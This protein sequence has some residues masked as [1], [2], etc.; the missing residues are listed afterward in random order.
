VVWLV[1]VRWGVVGVGLAAVLAGW[2]L[3]PAAACWEGLLA[4]VAGVGASNVVWAGRIR[5]GANAGCGENVRFSLWQVVADFVFLAVAVHLAGGIAGPL[6]PLFVLHGVFSAVLLPSAYALGVAGWAALLLVSSVLLERVWG[7]LPMF[8]LGDPGFGPAWFSPLLSFGFLGLAAGGASLIGLQL[9]GQLRTRHA[10]VAELA[11]ELSLRNAA[12][13]EVDEQRLRLLGVAS[14]DL[15]GPLAAMESR[16]DLFLGGYLGDLTTDQRTHLERVQARLREL[17]DF[18][19]DLLDLTAV[20]TTTAPVPEAET[21]DVARQ[22]RDAVSEMTPWAESKGV[23]LELVGAD[24][25]RSVRAPRAR[26]GLVWS[27]LLS[28]GVKY[29]GG[30]PVAVSVE[31][32]DRYVRVVVRDRGPG[33]PAEQLGRLFTEFY[34]TPAA[35]ASGIPGTGLGLAISRRVVRTAGGGIDVRSEP[36]EGTSFTVRLPLVEPEEPPG[37]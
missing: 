8:R 35:K 9:A 11:G 23:P 7:W 17:R 36:G 13:R 16:L 19:K 10:R 29:G 21:F 24:R 14:H 28:N 31:D 22:V 3:W 32:D 4:V 27:N 18:I 37:R 26:L 1:R 30:R 12:L 25:P 15:G 33:I 6:A 20:E 34:R 5:A 2:G